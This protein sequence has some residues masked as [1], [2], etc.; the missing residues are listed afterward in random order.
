ML[1]SIFDGVSSPTFDRIKEIIMDMKNNKALGTYNLQAELLT[2][3]G[4]ELKKKITEIVT[5]Y[6]R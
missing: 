2:Y 6:G 1:S 5:N 4:S 3:D